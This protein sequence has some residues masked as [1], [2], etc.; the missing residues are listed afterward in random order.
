MANFLSF[1]SKLHNK[2]H[3]RHNDTENNNF[4]SNVWKNDGLTVDR[5]SKSS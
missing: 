4:S 1:I 3:N 5:G 2:K